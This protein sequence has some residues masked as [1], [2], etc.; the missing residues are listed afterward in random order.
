MRGDAAGLGELPVADPAVERLLPRVGAAVGSQ[1]GR[2]GEGFVAAV[3]SIRAL[4]TVST[5]VR[6]QSAGSGVTEFGKDWL[7]RSDCIQQ[8][9]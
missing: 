4:A 7:V 6:L 5:H 8:V 2:L 1:V 9:C 3:A